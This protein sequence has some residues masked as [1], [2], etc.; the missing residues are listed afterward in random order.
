MTAI[1]TDAHYRMSVS[2]IRD[3]AELGVRVVACEKA[4][5]QSPV[6][7]ASRAVSRRVFLEDAAYLEALFS[8]CQEIYEQEGEKPALLPV[9]AKTLAALSEQSA[10]FSAVC[11]LC[12]A[13]PAQLARLNDKEAV[14][15][16]AKACGVPIP[17]S[18]TKNPGENEDAFFARVPLPCA[19]KPHCG[20]KLGLPAAA[21]YRIAK[22]KEELQAAYRH[23]FALAGEAPIVQ[24]FLPGEAYGCS[25]LA[26]DGA[27]LRAICH[28]R[29]REYPVS[30]GPS[31]CCECVENPELL[32]FAEMIIRESG[33]TGPAML[34]FKCGADGKPRLLEINPR[35]WGTFPLTR[36]SGSDFSYGWL[37]LAGGLPL[38]EECKPIHVKMVYYPADLIAALGYLKSGRPGMFFAALRDVFDPRVKPGLFSVKDP[39]PSFVYIQNLFHR[40][41]PS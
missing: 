25:V 14:A 23:F 4:S 38:P 40:R 16:L 17:E 41:R 29:V 13:S 35:V 24:E 5:L 3:L 7:F 33:F 36:A 39:K 9:G 31:S 37:C 12:V 21:R 11:G 19:V 27:I 22:T 2:L 6:G 34:E 28:R 20:E 10:R 32:A 26:K 1:V 15:A 8:L 30:G 18:F